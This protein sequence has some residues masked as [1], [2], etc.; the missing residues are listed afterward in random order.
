MGSFV[1]AVA[2][3]G[4]AHKVHKVLSSLEGGGGGV[5]TVPDLQ[6]PHFVAP[7]PPRN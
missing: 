7:P 4:G 6:F 5:Q 1:Y 2:E 3:G